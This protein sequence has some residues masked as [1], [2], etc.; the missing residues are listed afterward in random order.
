[1][2]LKLEKQPTVDALQTTLRVYHELEANE[3][4][5]MTASEDDPPPGDLGTESQEYLTGRKPAARHSA[6]MAAERHRAA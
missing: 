3:L 4:E 5:V 2:K 6:R 1:M